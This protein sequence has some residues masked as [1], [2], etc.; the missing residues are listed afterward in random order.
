MPSQS[1]YPYFYFFLFR[2]FPLSFQGETSSESFGRD[3]AIDATA[4]FSNLNLSSS[5]ASASPSASGDT[6]V[7]LGDR[8]RW[9]RGSPDYTGADSFDNILKKIDSTMSSTDDTKGEKGILR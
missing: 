3:H 4:V 2:N 5:G 9:E 8:N 6:G 1:T 7:R